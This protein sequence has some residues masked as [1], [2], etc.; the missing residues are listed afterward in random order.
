MQS[1]V[2]SGWS[3][4]SKIPGAARSDK[5]KET[6]MDKLTPFFKKKK[7]ILKK[8]LTKRRKAGI[9]TERLTE[10]MKKQESGR[11]R[12]GGSRTDF[13]KRAEKSA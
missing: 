11:K 6:H 9:L 1:W 4:M 8:G 13:R 12:P 7:R 5:A 10:G 3:A 2:A